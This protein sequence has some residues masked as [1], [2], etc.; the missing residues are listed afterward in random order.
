MDKLPELDC[1]CCSLIVLFFALDWDL[2]NI[3]ALYADMYSGELVAVNLLEELHTNATRETFKT[4]FNSLLALPY[5]P[6]G[7]T[8]TIR[9]VQ[10]GGAR[11]R[12]ALAL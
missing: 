5:I 9:V 4:V 2:V 6:C 3:S 11:S 7:T 1:C 12:I 10:M 8:R